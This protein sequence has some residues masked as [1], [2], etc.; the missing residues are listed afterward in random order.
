MRKV[1]ENSPLAE[2]LKDP[3]ARAIWDAAMAQFRPNSRKLLPAP[4]TVEVKATIDGHFCSLELS[5][6]MAASFASMA[7]SDGHEV[8]VKHHD[9]VVDAETGEEKL[10]TGPTGK[11]NW[12]G[13]RMRGPIEYWTDAHGMVLPIQEVHTR[14]LRSGVDTFEHTYT[15]K[16]GG[17]EHS[18][19]QWLSVH[20]APG[21]WTDLPEP[22]EVIPGGEVTVSPSFSLG[23]EIGFEPAL[24]QRKAEGKRKFIYE[25]KPTRVAKKF[26]ALIEDSGR[27]KKAALPGILHAKRTRASKEA[28]S[29]QAQRDL[30]Q[31]KAGWKQIRELN[32]GRKSVRETEIPLPEGKGYAPLPPSPKKGMSMRERFEKA[33]ALRLAREA[34]K[35]ADPRV[36]EIAACREKIANIQPKLNEVRAQLRDIKPR[37]VVQWHGR[38]EFSEKVRAQLEKR[39]HELLDS[40]YILQDKIEELEAV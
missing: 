20:A 40:I 7:D 26:L 11:L 24:P 18:L 29:V 31:L 37:T 23:E 30:E 38:P 12:K 36:A 32:A 13:Q 19:E 1:P 21:V 15:G 35:A 4:K 3:E 39:K 8:F 5:P 25:D 28:A 2:L 10:L 34:A 6:A 33:R 27:Q 16:Q 17:G 22:I 9:I 14:V